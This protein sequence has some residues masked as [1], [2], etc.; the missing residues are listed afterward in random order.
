MHTVDTSSAGSV[1]TPL[2]ADKITEILEKHGHPRPRDWLH[3]LAA[4]HVDAV[5]PTTPQDVQRFLINR[6]WRLQIGSVQENSLDVR[7]CLVDTGKIEHWL[8]LFDADVAKW[9]VAHNLPAAVH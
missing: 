2:L 3:G 7:Y 1:Q 9:I 8:R 6:Y 4:V 5:T